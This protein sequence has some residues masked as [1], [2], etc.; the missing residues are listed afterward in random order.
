M[1]PPG[2]TEFWAAEDA[3][4]P[5][6]EL[7]IEPVEAIQTLC[8]LGWYAQAVGRGDLAYLHVREHFTEVKGNFGM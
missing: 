1:M 2:A 6:H 5:V 8:L 4:P 3:L 7:L